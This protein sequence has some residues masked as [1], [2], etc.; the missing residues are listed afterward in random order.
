M[1]ATKLVIGAG[2]LIVLGAVA[3]APTAAASAW[4]E[5][6]LAECILDL[7]G[8]GPNPP[9]ISCQGPNEDNFTTQLEQCQRAIEGN[10]PTVGTPEQEC[11]DVS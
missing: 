1:K 3:L 11:Y 8:Q 9:G 2:M 5:Y 4:D 7:A 6:S 10:D